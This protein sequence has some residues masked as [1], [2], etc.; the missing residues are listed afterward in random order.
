MQNLRND[1]QS[2]QRKLEVCE[3]KLA[4]KVKEVKD[5]DNFIKSTI[6]GRSKQEDVP[7]IVAELQRVFE[8]DYIS[9]LAEAN[10]PLKELQ[11]KEASK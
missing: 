1:V 8:A 6:I 3:T 9:K 2:L 7:F 5:K 4:I 11:S 10:N